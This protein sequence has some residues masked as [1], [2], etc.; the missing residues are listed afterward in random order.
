MPKASDVERDSGR[1]RGVAKESQQICGVTVFSER[2][3]L[4][5]AFQSEM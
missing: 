3:T 5:A 2:Q 4:I 1:N